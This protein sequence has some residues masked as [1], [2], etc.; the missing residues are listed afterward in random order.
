MTDPVRFTAEEEAALVQKAQGGDVE[1]R[2]LVVMSVNEMC[3]Y[4]AGRYGR[5][6]RELIE[7]LQ[8][9]AI[10][11]LCEKFHQFD[12]SIGCRFITWAV[13]WIKQAVRRYIEE[14]EHHGIRVPIHV[15]RGEADE[16]RLLLA[17]VARGISSLDADMSS[18]GDGFTLRDVARDY[19][20]PAPEDSSLRA[21][22]VEFVRKV[23]QRIHPRYRQ[24]LE[25]RSRMCLEEAG[26]QLGITR[27]RV[28]QLE[29]KACKKFVKEAESVNLRLVHGLEE[30]I[31]ESNRHWAK[32]FLT[33]RNEVEA[34]TVKKLS[35]VQQCIDALS[36][37]GEAAKS[38]KH[39]EIIE[40]LAKQGVTVFPADISNARLKLYGKQKEPKPSTSLQVKSPSAAIVPGSLSLDYL[41]VINTFAKSVGGL[42]RLHEAVSFLQELKEEAA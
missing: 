2:N 1:A 36:G 27:E 32:R 22:R 23:L 20:E 39:K 38:M 8:R 33:R 4:W 40:L 15:Q 42:D 7:Q 12:L 41:R 37:L 21:D 9:E 3:W 10:A 17:R 34:P 28:R 18:E 30:E 16:G 14:K 5:R 35:K 24:I 19:R 25:L 6:N 11:K 13:N 29:A 26:E 31:R